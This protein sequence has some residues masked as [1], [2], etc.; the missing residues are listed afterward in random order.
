MRTATCTISTRSCP[1][2]NWPRG[3]D[4]QRET[5]SKAIEKASIAATDRPLTLVA[6]FIQALT[7]SHE[8]ESLVKASIVSDV[9]S[10]RDVIGGAAR[11]AVRTADINIDQLDRLCSSVAT[12]LRARR[13]DLVTALDEAL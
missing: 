5:R 11:A 10:G 6:K 4:A 1:R 3:D 8:V 7:V 12:T 2:T 9:L 13:D